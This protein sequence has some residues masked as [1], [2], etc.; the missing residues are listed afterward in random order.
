VYAI[1]ESTQLRNGH[2]LK[3]FLPLLYIGLIVLVLAFTAMTRSEPE[4]VTPLSAVPDFGMQ[5]PENYREEFVLYLVVERIDQTVRNVYIHPDAIAALQAN[6]ELPYGTQIVIETWDA[7]PDYGNFV[8][9]RRYVPQALRPNIHVMEKRENWTVQDLPSPVG[10]ID[11]NFGSF[12]RETFLPSSEN[13]NDCLTCHDGG[14]FRRDFVFSHI[15][16]DAFVASGDIQYLY[17]SLPERA[18]C[19]R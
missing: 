17:C 8:A 19:I 18:N 15:F 2:M 1:D 4:I 3:K 14:A 12:D 16:I 11:W 7:R 6:E 13:R 5:F 9:D 10:V